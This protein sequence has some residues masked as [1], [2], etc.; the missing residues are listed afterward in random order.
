L[1]RGFVRP[2]AG[3]RELLRVARAAAI[4]G[5]ACGIGIAMIYGSV[6]A[7]VGV[8]YAI[9]T[10]TLSVP[11]IGGLFVGRARR[12]HGVAALSSGIP[13]LLLVQVLT[14]GRGYG[15]VSPV[16]AGL[17]ASAAGFALADRFNILNR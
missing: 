8:F 14:G 15:V 12:A 11:L 9:L 5:G 1:Y 6:R 16:L 2:D 17:L 7:A 3:D 10:V 4:V 13:V